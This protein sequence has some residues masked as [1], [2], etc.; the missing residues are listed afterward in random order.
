MTSLA[1]PVA[2]PQ[3]LL[4]VLLSRLFYQAF[5][6]RDAPRRELS[7]THYRMMLRVRDAKARGGNMNEAVT[8]NWSSRAL[9]W[10]LNP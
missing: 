5:P 9:D 1:S 3:V 8:Q 7:W 2:V 10:Q 6:I 4:E